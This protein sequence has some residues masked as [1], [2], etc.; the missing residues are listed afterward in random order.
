MDCAV[1]QKV[2]EEVHS[3]MQALPRNSIIVTKS[4]D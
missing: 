2:A 3:A 4:A 1:K